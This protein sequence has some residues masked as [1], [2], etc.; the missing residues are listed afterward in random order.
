MADA[1]ISLRPPTSPSSRRRARRRIS[2]S[3]EED[4]EDEDVADEEQTID[5]EEQVSSP[6]KHKKA[7]SK[8]PKV[9]STAITVT[10]T[11]SYMV[12]LKFITLVLK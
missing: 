8:T 6:R 7:I 11:H 5:E 4:E 10:I 12:L 2:S 9:Y 3:E 1:G